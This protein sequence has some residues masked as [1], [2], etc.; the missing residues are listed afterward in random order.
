MACSVMDEGMYLQDEEGMLAIINEDNMNAALDMATN[1]MEVLAFISKEIAGLPAKDV[2]AE[3]ILATT[4]SRFGTKA[5]NDADLK[6]LY[7][8][9]LMVPSPLIRNLTELHF[10]L[11]PA[12]LLRCPPKHF[13]NIANVDGGGLNPYSKATPLETMWTYVRTYVRTCTCPCTY[14]RTSLHM[15]MRQCS[16]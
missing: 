1:E 16:V 12:A 5:F 15:Y 7:N 3:K 14:V 2:N 8:Y 9:A 4:K 11:V 10:S 6:S 13:H